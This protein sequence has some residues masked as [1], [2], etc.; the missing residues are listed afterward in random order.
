[1]RRWL[2][3]F[4]SQGLQDRVQAKLAYLQSIFTIAH[5]LIYKS[6]SPGAQN[7]STT[8][9]LEKKYISVLRHLCIEGSV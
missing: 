9:S 2:C 8:C 3:H 1:M 5:R 6:S 7:I 4:S